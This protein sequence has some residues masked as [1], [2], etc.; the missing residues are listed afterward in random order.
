MLHIHIR[1]EAMTSRQDAMYSVRSV[2]PIVSLD[3]PCSSA[4]CFV[5]LASIL[6]IWMS[7][8]SIRQV[9]VSIAP[10]QASVLC[11]LRTEPFGFLER[12]RHFVTFSYPDLGLLLADDVFHPYVSRVLYLEFADE[13]RI[14]QLACNS[15]I[16]AAAHQCVGFA[17]FCSGS[18]AL[19]GEVVLFTPRDGHQPTRNVSVMVQM[20]PRGKQ[21][22]TDRPCASRAYSRVTAFAVTV[23]SPRGASPQPPGPNAWFSI[24]L[25]LISGR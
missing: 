9:A 11:S 6:H 3:R 21:N 23:L 2:L 17:A 1:C 19:R 14:P 4:S 25:Y 5:L 18:N 24:R 16:F 13:S 8:C 15:Q 20:E 7:D 22:Q 12:V 10:G